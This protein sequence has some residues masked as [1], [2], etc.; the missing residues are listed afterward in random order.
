[1]FVRA[2]AVS[3]FPFRVRRPDFSFPFL[4][5]DFV[6]RMFYPYLVFAYAPGYIRTDTFYRIG[7]FKRHLAYQVDLP[8]ISVQRMPE[9]M[10]AA[11]G[12]IVEAPVAVFLFIVLDVL[13]H[14]KDRI[15]YHIF[16]QV[17]RI[18]PVPGISEQ[19]ARYQ[20]EVQAHTLCRPSGLLTF[21][22]L[23]GEL[24]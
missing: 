4:V 20:P 1:M 16:M 18:V 23:F 7:E 11:S 6:F 15:G 12:E 3:S 2:G 10:F 17:F 5:S 21:L 24:L 19:M 9:R 22:Q 8:V 13:Y 14:L